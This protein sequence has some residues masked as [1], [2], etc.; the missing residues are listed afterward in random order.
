MWLLGR[1]LVD[2]PAELDRVRIMQDRVLL[3]TP[4]MRNERRILEAAGYDVETAV[5]GLD[6]WTKLSHAR[7]D[8]V[9]SDINM[10]RMSGLELTEKIRAAAAHADLP[11]VLVTSRA[12]EADRRRGLEVGADAYIA[13]PE[14]DQ[15][16]LLDSL[17]RL[18]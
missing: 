10:P 1:I 17:A 8:A 2:S 9:V 11:V 16:L 3:E 5:D 18:L 12:T 4:D 13:K 7:F 6:A 14:F 15:T